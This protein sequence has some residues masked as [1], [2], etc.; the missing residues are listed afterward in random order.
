[1]GLMIGF[2][3]HSFQEFLTARYMLGELDTS[4]MTS[5]CDEYLGGSD[6]WQ[7]VLFFYIDL[8]AKPKETLHWIE[9]RLRGYTRFSGARSAA[10][11]ERASLLKQHLVDSFPYA[12]YQAQLKTEAVALR[13]QRAL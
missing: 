3:H 4:Q 7:E 6:W 11:K 13:K 2:A 10:A 8:V 12:K 9:E 5:C 1:M